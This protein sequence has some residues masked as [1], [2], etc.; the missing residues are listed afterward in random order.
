[1]EPEECF[2]HQN[3]GK[4]VETVSENPEEDFSHLSAEEQVVLR[5][6]SKIINRTPSKC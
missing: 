3:S 1:L 2:S 6:I 4:Q 5:N